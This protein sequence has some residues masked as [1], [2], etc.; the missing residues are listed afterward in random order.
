M[1]DTIE[2]EG[3]EEAWT[4]KY[5]DEQDCGT[6]LKDPPTYQRILLSVEFEFNGLF[7]PIKKIEPIDT[8]RREGYAKLYQK[9]MKQVEL[10]SHLWIQKT[11]NNP[12][13]PLELRKNE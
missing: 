8:F 3:E 5:L 7:N 4:E 6:D 9:W 10:T 12:H 11:I 13:K 2:E 1:D